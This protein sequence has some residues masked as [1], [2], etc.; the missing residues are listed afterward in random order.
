MA[1]L[2]NAFVPARLC[3]FTVAEA[4]RWRGPITACDL[5]FTIGTSPRAFAQ[6]LQETYHETKRAASKG[7]CAL[8]KRAP[9]P[10]LWEAGLLTIHLLAPM[11]F[12]RTKL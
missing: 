10:E 4:A 9:Q 2:E 5:L 7:L 6:I 11:S 8:N 3:S 1:Q 12:S